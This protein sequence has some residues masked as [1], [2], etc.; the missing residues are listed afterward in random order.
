M[1]LPVSALLVLLLIPASFATDVTVR[2]T[3]GADFTTI[4]AALDSIQKGALGK[5]GTPDTITILDSAVYNEQLNIGNIPAS[6]SHPGNTEAWLALTTPSDLDPITIQGAEGEMPFIEYTGDM[7]EDYGVFPDDAG[8]NFKANIAYL[9]TSITLKNLVLNYTPEVGSAGAYMLNGQARDLVFED[10][11]FK[12]DDDPN[13]F[14]GES[15]INLN[16]SDIL[17]RQEGVDN[18]NT[19]LRN[20]VVDGTQAIFYRTGNEFL[21]FHGFDSVGTP[22]TPG[23]LIENT[24]F[25]MWPECVRMRGR[26]ADREYTT[27]TSIG[28]FFYEN[29]DCLRVEGN[30]M[31]KVDQTL[32]T[33]NMNDWDLTRDGGIIYLAERSGWVPAAEISNS[34]FYNNGSFELGVDE[35]VPNSAIRVRARTDGNTGPVVID[36][37]TFDGNGRVI[38]LSDADQARE[39]IFS[40]SIVSNSDISLL[41]MTALAGNPGLVTGTID[42]VLGYQNAALIV[43]DDVSFPNLAIADYFEADPLY[44]PATTNIDTNAPWA[45]PAFELTE[46]S[47]AIDRGNDDMTIGDM[48]VDG[49]PRISRD[50]S[51]L[52]AQELD[53]GPPTGDLEPPVITEISTNGTVVQITWTGTS[54]AYQPQRRNTMNDAWEDLGVPIAATTTTDPSPPSPSA[55][56]RILPLASLPQ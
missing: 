13:T 3:G 47:P 29:G 19:V 4:Q 23:L 42:A 41:D 6:S 31:I 22:L 38:W 14:S 43:P 35:G 18:S 8:D 32:F 54:A 27:V 48:D 26:P 49:D 33:R 44:D 20:C 5:D 21:Y 11:L 53:L 10:V 7:L 36:H 37:C 52:G 40:N 30:G 39:L 46:P 51:D 15:Y 25:T 12:Y 17:A 9:G 55:F 56:Y 24:T 28:N 2:S 16:N 1:L 34:V 50:A 45:V